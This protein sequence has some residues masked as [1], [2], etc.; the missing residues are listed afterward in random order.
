MIF[1]TWLALFR[2]KFKDFEDFVIT[3]NN[4]FKKKPKAFRNRLLKDTDMVLDCTEF[5]CEST[6]DYEVQG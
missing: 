5:Q 2:A 1:K 3:K 4:K 6:K